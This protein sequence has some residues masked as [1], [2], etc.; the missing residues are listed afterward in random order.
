MRRSR[1]GEP[2]GLSADQMDGDGG[3]EVEEGFNDMG[4]VAGNCIQQHEATMTKLKLSPV[5]RLSHQAAIAMVLPH[6]P[7][8]PIGSNVHRRHLRVGPAGN[9]KL[10]PYLA[11]LRT[12]DAH[13]VMGRCGADIGAHDPI[14][15]CIDTR[16][17]DDTL[18]GQ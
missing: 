2:V 8:C 3:M 9:A 6:N 18:R 10:L 1:Q 13:R 16:I 4:A 5:D 12:I 17:T 15:V 14:L 11:L 7:Q